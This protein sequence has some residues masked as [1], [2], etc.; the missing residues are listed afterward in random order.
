VEYPEVRWVRQITEQIEP[1]DLEAS[2]DREL[3]S[4]GVLAAIGS[5]SRVVIAA[6]SRGIPN[7]ARVIRHVVQRIQQRGADVAILPAMGSHGGA[8]AAGQVQILADLGIT[9]AGVGA[10]VIDTMDVV[11]LGTTPLGIPALADRALIDCDHIIVAN[12]IKEHTEFSGS[13]ESGLCKMMAIGFGRALGAVVTHQHA[14]A[15]GYEA[16]IL[17][18]AELCIDRL[19]VLAGIGLLDTP[20]GDTAKVAVVP[21]PEILTREPELL[22]ESRHLKPK[23][24]LDQVD[25]L[26]IDEMGKDVSGT[27]MDTK[28]IGRVM[29][30][31]EPE[32]EHPSITRIFVRDLTPATHG[33]ALGIGLA[34]FTSRR[35]VDKIDWHATNINCVTAVT[36][37]KARLPMTF[38]TEREAVEAGLATIGPKS[39]EE[40][41]MLWIR[42]TTDIVELLAT[43]AAI[44]AMDGQTVEIVGERHPLAFGNGGDLSPIAGPA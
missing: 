5:G 36:P 16:A 26:I 29:N 43:Q 31:Y 25:L 6:G 10:R 19:P 8:E 15:C 44:E 34:D 17:D 32:P 35:L 41:R 11:A 20:D 24:P 28:V 1:I 30:V 22:E 14:V 33:N 42:N 40:V 2:L 23:L 38:E 37:E 27:G 12:R 4:S 7:Y 13:I 3:E 21:A 9:E 39:V 18:V